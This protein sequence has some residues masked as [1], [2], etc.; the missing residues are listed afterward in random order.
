[1]MI[2]VIIIVA[3]TTTVLLLLSLQLLFFS[4]IIAVN[5]VVLH[6]VLSFVV[7]FFVP[8]TELNAHSGRNIA[9]VEG[10]R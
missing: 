5:F 9:W 4:A 2:M 7:R 3:M 6:E 10:S 1:M 8:M